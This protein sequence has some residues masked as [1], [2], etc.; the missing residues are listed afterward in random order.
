MKKITI[1][2]VVL[3]SLGFMAGLARAVSTTTVLGLTLPVYGSYRWDLPMNANSQLIDSLVAVKAATQTFTGANTFVSTSN[4]YYGSGSNLSGVATSAQLTSTAAAL[5]SEIARATAR[6]DAIAVSTGV[7]QADLA[8]EVS[9]ATLRENDLGV[10][11]GTIY[12]ALNSTAAAL[13]SEIS[14]ATTRENAISVSTG[15]LEASKV[16]RAGDT[17]TGQLTLSGSTATIRY[18]SGTQALFNG[19]SLLGTS[20]DAANGSILFGN[21]ASYQ[22]IIDYNAAGNTTFSIKNTYAGSLSTIK[23]LIGTGIGFHFMGSDR[24]GIGDTT[25]DARLEI[26]AGA[27]DTPSSYLLAVSSQSDVTGNILS[28]LANGKMGL[29]I[30]VPT[31]LLHTDTDDRN[32]KVAILGNIDGAYDRGVTVWTADDPRPAGVQTWRPSLD[33]SIG[34]T[35]GYSYA[36]KM[37]WSLSA[38]GAAGKTSNAMKLSALSNLDSYATE[39]DIATFLGDG[40][41][42]I[43]KS[44]SY[45]LEV[46]TPETTGTNLVMG[47]IYGTAADNNGSTILRVTRNNRY[48]DIEYNGGNAGFRY[49]TYADMNI[50]N[51]YAETANPFGNINFVTGGATRMTV[52]GGTAGGKVGLGTSS[53]S[54]LLNIST[55]TGSAPSLTAHNGMFNITQGLVGTELQM[56]HYP[57]TPYAAWI[58]TKQPNNAG[59][60]WPLVLNPLGGNVGIGTSSPDARLTVVS[61]GT[62]LTDSW[63]VGQIAINDTSG[64]NSTYNAGITFKKNRDSSDNDIMV[65]AI[66]SSGTY[67]VGSGVGLAVYGPGASV[68]KIAI[69]P[70]MFIDNTG[71]VSLYNN[72]SLK[73]YTETKSSAAVATNY[74]VSW[75]SGSVYW[76]SLTDNVTL[77]FSGAVDGQSLTLFVKQNVGS[78]AITWPTISWPSATAPT[79]TTAAGKTD[80]ISLVYI[81][82]VYYGFIGGQN[83]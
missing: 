2:A 26:L 54:T 57:T 13:S 32:T 24:L 31:V 46:Y 71:Q 80:I 79:L 68:D 47:H 17:M 82:G 1:A 39:A 23:M 49:G 73:T 65:G 37:R 50:V 36:G 34:D 53:P 25:P 62:A 81:G 44:P 72:T 29:G 70:A 33:L 6:E 27:S 76:L 15:A 3:F 40:R 21:N 58:Q 66:A 61:S 12:A 9:R 43:G 64:F 59:G 78:K 45:K 20:A 38:T 48:G 41:V 67:G 63:P 77:T 52:Q 69:A 56:G 14:R 51:N 11:T 22:G 35:G 7:L 10:S 19:Y 28:V 74:D 8:T 55:A 30:S 5:S 16:N 75:S 4:V 83:Y 60:T 42:G 18:A